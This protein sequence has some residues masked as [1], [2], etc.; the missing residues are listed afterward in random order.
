[1]SIL[2]SSHL[3]FIVKLTLIAS[4]AYSVS[5]VNRRR[6]AVLGHLKSETGDQPAELLFSRE[7]PGADG[8]PA[9]MGLLKS[10]QPRESAD[11]SRGWPKARWLVRALG[12]ANRWWGPWPRR[13]GAVTVPSGPRP[14]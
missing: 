10:G 11:G 14:G 1:M 3:H 9:D 12:S 4:M 6:A 7:T 13:T 2:L 5:L 8:I